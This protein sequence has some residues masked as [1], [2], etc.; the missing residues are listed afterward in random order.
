MSGIRDRD[1]EHL[2]T[3]LE[4][5]AQVAVAAHVH[6]GGAR[7]RGE[8]TGEEIDG[9]LAL[10]RRDVALPEDERGL[11]EE[12]Q[13]RGVRRAERQQLVQC[14]HP[15]PHRFTGAPERDARGQARALPT[16]HRA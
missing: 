16:Q 10:E 2:R 4:R 14:A 12:Q 15:R 7:G 3:G 1:A 11:V 5:D 13:D 9:L 8:R 6:A